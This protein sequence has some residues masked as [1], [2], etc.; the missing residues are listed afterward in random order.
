LA[1]GIEYAS[2]VIGFWVPGLGRSVTTDWDIEGEHLAERCAL[3]IMI[4]LGESILVTGST[5]GGVAA[6]M[7]TT[8]AFVCAFLSSVAMWWIYFNI[9]VERGACQIATSADPGRLGRLV[10]TYI[11]I[12]IV[13][14]VIVA[15]VADELVLAHPLGH[16]EMRSMLPIIGGPALYLLGNLWFKHVIWGRPPLSHIVGLATLMLAGILSPK[17]TPL[18]LFSVATVILVGVAIWETL[19]L[20]SSADSDRPEASH[21]A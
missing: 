2:V 12:L 20:R 11:H 15:A 1:I 14:G 17:M 4:A 7:A 5:A 16:V 3:F 6:T 21:K 9:G 18:L 8:T 13:A 10:Y 19:S